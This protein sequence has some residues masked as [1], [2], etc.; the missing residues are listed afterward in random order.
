MP[1]LNV[2]LPDELHRQC[3][4]AAVGGGITLKQYLL[5]VLEEALRDER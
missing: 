1:H 5:N 3:K 4:L 2:S